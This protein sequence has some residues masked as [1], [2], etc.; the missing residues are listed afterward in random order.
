MGPESEP[1]ATDDI[2]VQQAYNPWTVVDVIFEH[3]TDQGF[4]PTLGSDGDPAEPAAALLR[5]LGVTPSQEGDPRV[6][7]RVHRELAHMRAQM[8]PVD[9]D[10]GRR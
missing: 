2:D 5:T 8:E 1:E 7:R 9:V 6:M 3:L 4:R 10:G